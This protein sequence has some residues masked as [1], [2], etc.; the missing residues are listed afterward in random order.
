YKKTFTV[1][2]EDSVKVTSIVFDGVYRNSSVWINGHYLGKRPNGYISFR[3]NLT[4]YLYYGNRQN[5]IIVKADNSKQPNSR[6]YSGSG[7]Y[8]NVWLETTDKLHVAADGTFVTTPQVSA[9]KAT[10]TL[11]TIIKNDYAA[12]KTAKVST[13]LYKGD[14]KITSV[15][16]E[17]TIPANAEKALSQETTVNNPVLW[18]VETPELYSA[19]TTIEI[20]G[21]VVD[22]YATPFG[23]RSFT[24]DLDKGFILNGKQVKIK[25]VCLHHDLGA[26]GSAF[27][28][29]AMERQL[30]IMKDMGVNGI[31]T[32]HNPPAPELLDLCDKMGFIVMD[33]AFD[34]WKQAKTPFDYS[35]DWDAWHK[36]DLAFT[37]SSLIMSG[38]LDSPPADAVGQGTSDPPDACRDPAK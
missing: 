3:Y 22:S 32:S 1:A 23:I 30:Q 8:R 24:F 5:E 28:T 26:L 33:E 6:W 38:R 18:N 36:K 31:R 10:V 13:T 12:Q 27:N 4:P 16:T 15:D 11:Q 34:M 17:T 25:G 21:E 37:R 29:R 7:I 20:D 14:D 35:N 19:V 9:Q 2:P